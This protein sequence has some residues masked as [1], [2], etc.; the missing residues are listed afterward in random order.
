VAISQLSGATDDRALIGDG[1]EWQATEIPDC[2]NATDD[3]LLYDQTTNTI[4]C[5]SDQGGV[6]TGD[7][8]AVGDA[9]SGA[10]FTDGVDNG[11]VLIYEGVSIDANENRLTFTGDPGADTVVT[12]PNETG[13]LLTSAT[14]L[15]GDVTGTSGATVVGDDSHAHTTTTIS[16]LATGDVTSG[17]F[18]DA[19]I[20]ESSVIQYVAAIDHDSLLNF[21]AGEHFLQSAIVETGTVATGTWSADLAADSVDAITEIAAALK[22]GA[23][24]TLITG[25]AGSD[26]YLSY[27]NADS[28][29]VGLPRIRFDD[30]NEEIDFYDDSNN[31]TATL[32]LATG[33]L[34]Q[35]KLVTTGIDETIGSAGDTG[36]SS[37]TIEAGDGA[38]NIEPS[39]YCG[40]GSPSFLSCFFPCDTDG[41][42]CIS[43]TKATADSSD[44]VTT[45]LNT[46][47]QDSGSTD[48]YACT[49]SPA[50]T[51]LTTGGQYRFKANTINTGAAA[52]DLNSIGSLAI[53]KLNDQ[54]LADGDIEA[55]QWVTVTYDGT[56]FQMDSQIANA[57]AGS[58]DITAVGDCL[59]GDSFVDGTDCGGQLVYE[60]SSVDA[61]QTILAFTGDPGGAYTVTIPN[62]TGTIITSVTSLVGDVTGTIGATVVPQ[63]SV[64][65]HATATPTATRIPLAEGDG[66]LNAGWIGQARHLHCGH[67][68]YGHRC[69]FRPTMVSLRDDQ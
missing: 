50:F 12:I 53:K 42:W 59:S 30:G 39:N 64:D 19:R 36:A 4:S 8:Q 28:D 54:D 17:T 46:S 68:V 32:D 34:T 21:V 40:Y 67:R 52:L 57:P 11:T 63:A 3:K 58:G 56:D 26:S 61:N 51:A 60:G 49:S 7:I 43:S 5:G 48:A 2:D 47:C 33:L 1:T 23:D 41:F 38:S 6:G 66:D 65:Q 10:A 20:S 37:M 13:T 9:T 31:N 25:T 22:S 55:G 69:H 62:E 18:A 27:W 29:L 15:A 44:F 14:T 35:G 45:L 24:A 16:G